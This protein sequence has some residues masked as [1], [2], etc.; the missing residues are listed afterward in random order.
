M[1]TATALF[2]GFAAIA[3]GNG[4][5]YKVSTKTSSIEWIGKKVTGEHNGTIKVADGEVT[6]TDGMISGGTLLID[7]NSIVVLD[8][9]DPEYNGKLTGHLKSDDFFGVEA[10]PQ[11]KL[12]INSV[13]S[14]GG[15]KF[16]IHGDLTIKGTT[17][18]VEIPATI[19]MEDNKMVV[20]GETEIDRTKYGIKY[21]SGQFFE[22]L[23]DKMIY[24][25][26]TVKFKVGAIK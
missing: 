22:D 12:V 14:K 9:E 24:D 2:I 25:N 5:T 13:E 10:H 16:H 4:E 26:F 18:K 15:E 19:K 17:Q 8:L 21:G 3:G 1:T 7:M 6:V 20:I 11:S 23:G